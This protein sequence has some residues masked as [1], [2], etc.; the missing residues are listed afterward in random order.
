MYVCLLKTSCFKFLACQV[1]TEVIFKIL[2]DLYGNDKTNQNKS[3][4]S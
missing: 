3:V 4:H 2:N 1:C